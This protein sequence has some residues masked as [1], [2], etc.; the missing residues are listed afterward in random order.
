M[1][2]GKRLY[3]RFVGLCDLAAILTNSV[4]R[5]SRLSNGSY[6]PGFSL[7]HRRS[8]DSGN[9]AN[10][11]WQGIQRAVEGMNWILGYERDGRLSR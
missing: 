5:L 10:A 2:W 4:R 7:V 8:R 1:P 9:S 11:D 3:Q 6:S